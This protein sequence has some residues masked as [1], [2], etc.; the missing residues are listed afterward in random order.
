MIGTLK[1]YLHNT[2]LNVKRWLQ[3]DNS[4]SQILEIADIKTAY[5]EAGVLVLFC[6]QVVDSK[7]LKTRKFDN[8]KIVVEFINNFYTKSAF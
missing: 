3:K 1:L 6:S 5:N 8:R 2:K 4:Q 7:W